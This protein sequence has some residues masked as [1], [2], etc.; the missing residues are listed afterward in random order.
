M[1]S[2]KPEDFSSLLVIE[3]DELPPTAVTHKQ[4]TLRRAQ[5]EENQD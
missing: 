3:R 4:C 2:K 5:D 1:R